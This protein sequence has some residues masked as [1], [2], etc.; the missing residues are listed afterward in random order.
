MLFGRNICMKR[1]INIYRNLTTQRI[2]RNIIFRD[3]MRCE[4]TTKMD[5][6]YYHGTSAPWQMQIFKYL[7]LNFRKE[8]YWNN[9]YRGVRE[10]NGFLLLSC[11]PT[12][13]P[14]KQ[15]LLIFFSFLHF[16][17]VCEVFQVFPCLCCPRD[18]VKYT[19][20]SQAI[21]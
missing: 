17:A 1:Q 15:T 7:K 2:F 18:K 10:A 5:D 4:K 6:M 12:S 8:L 20:D 14:N 11:W 16:R 9:E 3:I 13:Y 19:S 21:F